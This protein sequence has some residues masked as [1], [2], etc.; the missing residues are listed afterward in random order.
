MAATANISPHESTQL[1]TRV[2]ML[3]EELELELE[4]GLP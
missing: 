1:V 3:E 4:L 2:V